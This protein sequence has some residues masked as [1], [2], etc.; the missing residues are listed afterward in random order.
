MKDETVKKEKK[1]DVPET[2]FIEI[3]VSKKEPDE[4]KVEDIDVDEDKDFG[5]SPDECKAELN[6]QD[7][8]RKRKVT[9][10]PD[11]ESDVPLQTRDIDLERIED[12]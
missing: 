5:L 6:H 1:E 9:E 3:D 12:E 2:K 4:P 11:R 8:Q 10:F 7:R